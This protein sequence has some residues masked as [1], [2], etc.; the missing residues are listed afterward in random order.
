[1]KHYLDDLYALK[2]IIDSKQVILSPTD[3][4]WSLLCDALDEEA[5]NTLYL[6]KSPLVQEDMEIIVHSIG[7]LKGYIS[8]IHPRIETLIHYHERPLSVYCMPNI[9]MPA[10]IYNIEKDLAFRVTRDPL[11]LDLISVLDRPL[12]SVPASVNP[13]HYPS[14]FSD[15]DTRI[16]DQCAYIVRSHRHLRGRMKPAVL[17][18]C[19]DEGELIFHRE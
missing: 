2:D 17:I 3:T 15:I 18:S 8:H 9:M 11:L 19:D 1:M 14:H 6:I 5:V 10:S 4:V 16:T 13:G 7:Q 12:L